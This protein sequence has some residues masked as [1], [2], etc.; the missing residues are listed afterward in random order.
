MRRL[1]IAVRAGMFALVSGLI[2]YASLAP[3]QALPE[4]SL[5]DKA[6]HALAW[7]G[8]TLLGLGFWP[9]R[10][11]AIAAYA[12]ALGLMVEFG[13]ANMD[14]GRMGDWRDLLADAI[15]I[16]AALGLAR[17]FG[18]GRGGVGHGA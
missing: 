8:L 7:A 16:A 1:P 11:W 5:W 13:Q 10:R 6:E 18:G 12:L 14:L 2:L 15:G 4:V 17:L 3:A 9:G